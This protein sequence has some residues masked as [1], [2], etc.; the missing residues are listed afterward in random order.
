VASSQAPAGSA[1]ER[2]EPVRVAIALGSNLGDRHDTLS[3]AG[4]ELAS[5]LDGF[6]LSSF[7]D[8]AP[9]GVAG[10]QPRYLNAAAS[11]LTRLTPRALLERL[12][13]LETARGRTRPAPNA[14]RT[15]DLDLILYGT[16]VVHEAGLTVPHPRFR[17][18]AFVLAPLAEIAGDMVDPVT[19]LTVERLL[20]ALLSFR[21]A[22]P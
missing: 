10:P 3:R 18:R 6:T 15:L 20:A 9:V 5:F 4:S 1:T 16:S 11:G 17:E 12:L 2:D 19:G 21:G 7:H 22:E 13:A 8:T 14:P